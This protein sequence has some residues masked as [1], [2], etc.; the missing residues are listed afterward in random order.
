[1]SIGFGL[2]AFSP[3]GPEYSTY[4]I[5][6]GLWSAVVVALVGVLLGHN[7]PVVYAPRSMSM[8]LVNS[9]IAYLLSAHYLSQQPSSPGSCSRRFS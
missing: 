5:V 1:M 4:G 8:F 3:L 7:G 6:A 2:F 9:T